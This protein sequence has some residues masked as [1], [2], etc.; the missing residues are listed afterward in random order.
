MEGGVPGSVAA[1]AG[2]LDEKAA[3]SSKQPGSPVSVLAE[4]STSSEAGSSSNAQAVVASIMK[5]MKKVLGNFGASSSGAEGGEGANVDT[6]DE[7]EED[8]LSCIQNQGGDSTDEGSRER[9]KSKQPVDQQP[10]GLKI[11]TEVPKESGSGSDGSQQQASPSQVSP[12][13]ALFAGVRRVLD[14]L[15]RGSDSA[16]RPR[17]PTKA[18]SVLDSEKIATLNGER[19]T[20]REIRDWIVIFSKKLLDP[21]VSPSSNTDYKVLEELKQLSSRLKSGSLKEKD[22]SGNGL[23]DLMLTELQAVAMHF[24]GTKGED[25]GLGV[26]GFEILESG[27]VDGLSQY[28]TRPAT[29]EVLLNSSSEVTQTP[30]RHSASLILRLKAFLHVFLNGPPPKDGCSLYVSDAFANLVARLQESLSRVERFDVALAI[31]PQTS[32]ASESIMGL[33]G[34]LFGGGAHAGQIRA[35]HANPMM[36]LS[37]QVKLRLIAEESEGIPTAYHQMLISIHAIATMK[38]LEDYLKARIGPMTSSAPAVGKTADGGSSSNEPTAVSGGEAKSA[39]SGTGSG[40]AVVANLPDGPPTPQTANIGGNLPGTPSKSGME[41]DKK[42][43]ETEEA[44]DPMDHDMDEDENED[45]LEH[46]GDDGDDDDDDDGDGDEIVNVSDLLLQSEEAQRRGRRSLV[47]ASGETDN[48]PI[49]GQPVDSKTMENGANLRESVVDVISSSTPAAASPLAA[50]LLTGKP[51]SSVD[52]TPS[53]SSNAAATS[54]RAALS[55]ASGQTR[56]YASAATDGQNNYQIVFTLGKNEIDKDKTIFATLYEHEKAKNANMSR[57]SPNIWNGHHVIKYKRA[58]RSDSSSTPQGEQDADVILNDQSMSVDSVVVKTPFRV[59]IPSDI[60][61]DSYSGKILYLLRVLQTLNS[62]WSEVFEEESS[63]SSW[64]AKSAQVVGAA[65]AAADGAIGVVTESV[66]QFHIA[67]AT[68]NRISPLAADAFTN[69]KITAKLN[70]QLDEPLIVASGVLPSWCSYIARDF[71]FLVPFESRMIHLQSTSFGFS[72]SMGRWQ[73]QQQQNNQTSS[74]N[75]SLSWMGS[76]GGRNEMPSIGR[77][78]RQKVRISR[79]RI[80]ESMLKVMDL[81]GSTQ[82]LLEVEFFDEVGTGLGPT[83]EFYSMICKELRRRNGV[84]LGS[85]STAASATKESDP[86]AAALQAAG[87]TASGQRVVIWRSDGVVPTSQAPADDDDQYL[88]PASGLFPAPLSNDQARSESGKK[89]LNLFK[90]MG[91]FVAKAMLD[92]RLLDL[93]ISPLFLEMVVGT[94][95]K[96]RSRSQHA[97]GRAGRLASELHLLKHVDPMLYQ[98]LAE[99]NRFVHIQNVIQMDSSLSAEEKSSRLSGVS[100]RG[101]KLEDLCLDFTLPGYPGVELIPKGPE[102]PVTTSNLGDYIEAIVDL[103]VGEGVQRQVDAFRRGFDKVFPASDLRC[104]SVQELSLILGGN[105]S[106]DWS[107]E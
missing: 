39:T 38:S 90:S 99:L 84:L 55:S 101:A 45:D 18:T 96:D 16:D 72:R 30:S 77:I 59:D 68:P 12:G 66:S 100:V 5:D 42:K 26:T 47:G 50:A 60:G 76:G 20:E 98:S 80:V 19:F 40:S 11:D 32:S 79:Q 58:A 82:M 73:Q 22:S 44:G 1:A 17:S 25:D 95:Q 36:Q 61:F 46:D 56:S 102:T 3:T 81:Y 70:R 43:E 65:A 105:D 62:R 74:S 88:N 13:T 28:L 106:E 29:G 53:R 86:A 9:R 27:I 7:D 67:D 52:G 85:A 48:V 2:K 71:S 87:V 21:V 97:H 83:L 33:F 54:M 37:R 8:P 93:P 24:A 103:T 104:F 75:G 57:F 41:A 31:P 49:P 34:S 78:Q 92:S 15:T 69:S 14:R 23:D 4:A 94:E 51:P 63:L 89:T 35:E 91:T 64:A 6:M 10:K 107:I